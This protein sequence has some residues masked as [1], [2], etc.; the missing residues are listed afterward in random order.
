MAAESPFLACQKIGAARLR[1]VDNGVV[2]IISSLLL[3]AAFSSGF[4]IE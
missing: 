4:A 2:T 3:F 1:D